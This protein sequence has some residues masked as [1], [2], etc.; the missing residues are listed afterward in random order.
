M[1]N[2]IPSPEND[3]F[4]VILIVNVV[5]KDDG[6]TGTGNRKR[7]LPTSLVSFAPSGVMFRLP[8]LAFTDPKQIKLLPFSQLDE[9]NDGKE[10]FCEP[11]KVG[12]ARWIKK[13]R[14]GMFDNILMQVSVIV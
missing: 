1:T 10:K 14:D 4:D 13:M 9:S 6:H 2:A 3:E 8:F 5:E 7:T 12:N 11:T